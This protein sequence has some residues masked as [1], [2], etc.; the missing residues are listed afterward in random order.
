MDRGDG[1]VLLIHFLAG[2]YFS[3]S[4]RFGNKE[5]LIYLVC[6][7]LKFN[8]HMA[9]TVIHKGFDLC[10][11]VAFEMGFCLFPDTDYS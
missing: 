5:L 1:L 9:L 4:Y 7:L 2:E 11:S 3:V 6:I 10:G 8:T